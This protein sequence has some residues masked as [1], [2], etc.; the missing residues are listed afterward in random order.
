MKQ[1]LKNRSGFISNILTPVSGQVANLI[2]QKNGNIR[3]KN[4]RVP[5][6]RPAK[7]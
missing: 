1:K 5:V 2:F 3:L 6:K 7:K 4:P